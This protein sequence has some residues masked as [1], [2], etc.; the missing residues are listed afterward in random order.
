M[1]EYPTVHVSILLLTSFCAVL[2]SVYWKRCRYK[3]FHTHLFRRLHT[4]TR[5][6][7]VESLGPTYTNACSRVTDVSM[8]LS[9]TYRLGLCESQRQDSWALGFSRHWEAVHAVTKSCKKNKPVTLIR[10][11]Y[12]FLINMLRKNNHCRSIINC[13]M[14]SR[15]GWPHTGQPSCL[16][17]QQPRPVRRA[18]NHP[19]RARVP[20][21]FSR[22]LTLLRP[23]GL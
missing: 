8:R 2:C 11:C 18:T 13:K 1:S 3:H 14:A 5:L 20:S 9:Q 16:R 15:G 17:Q 22:V 12:F 4:Y 6:P 21:R 23:H 7:R 10:F 19:L